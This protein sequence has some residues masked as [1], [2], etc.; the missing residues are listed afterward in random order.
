MEVVYRDEYIMVVNKP[1]GIASQPAKMETPTILDE[2]DKSF[3]PVNRLDQRVSGLMLLATE[4]NISILSEALQQRTIIK[5]YRAV[6]GN[7][8]DAIT[9]QVIHWLLKDAQHSKSK[10]FTKEVAHSKKAEL[11]YQLVQS[12]EKYHLL[13]IDLRTGR[14]H[15]IR[16]QLAAIGCPIVGDVKYGYKRTTPDGSIFLQS[17]SL[18]FPH[19]VS[20]QEL[21]FEID[22]PELWKR[23]GFE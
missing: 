8:P 1:A 5:R 6:V 13:D 2:M 18:T 12:S 19:P 23:Y 16:A 9:A 20:G 10:V 22:M 21:H 7:K 11:T 14:F 4:K 3:I 17:Y 15:Q